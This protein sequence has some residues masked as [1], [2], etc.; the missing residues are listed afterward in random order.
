MAGLSAQPSG[1]ENFKLAELTVLRV[2]PKATLVMTLLQR[3]HNP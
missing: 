3:L 1:Y 2:Y